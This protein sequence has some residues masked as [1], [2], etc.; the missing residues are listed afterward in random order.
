MP[1][2]L[3]VTTSAPP[4]RTSAAASSADAARCSGE[5][6][7]HTAAD[8]AAPARP[9][10]HRR[11]RRHE[12]RR[13]AGDCVAGTDLMAGMADQPPSKKLE[14]PAGEER[15]VTQNR[16]P[17]KMGARSLTRMCSSRLPPSS[18][19][20]RCQGRAGHGC[21]RGLRALMRKASGWKHPL[22]IARLSVERASTRS[23][24]VE[25]LCA[26]VAVMRELVRHHA[27]PRF[28]VAAEGLVELGDS[29]RQGALGAPT[30]WSGETLWSGDSCSRRGLI[31][32]VP[33]SS[34]LA[35]AL[36]R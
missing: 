16:W 14:C 35:H 4:C 12:P 30:L 33:S 25:R 13:D 17:I 3:N 26:I 10:A 36:V 32:I 21:H 24:H 27:M 15:W 31:G 11:G 29:D 18:A 19:V 7:P 1:Q 5:S 23:R 6:A 34:N 22:C 2:T 20:W 28:V 8:A 9:A